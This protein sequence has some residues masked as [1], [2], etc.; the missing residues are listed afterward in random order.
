MDNSFVEG[1]NEIVS[2]RNIGRL[3]NMYPTGY[4]ESGP[5]QVR[6][7]GIQLGQDARRVSRE[8]FNRLVDWISNLEAPSLYSSDLL[9]KEQLENMRNNK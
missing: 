4:Y 9:T 8:Q 7:W 6:E 2:N 5:K 1:V 3:E